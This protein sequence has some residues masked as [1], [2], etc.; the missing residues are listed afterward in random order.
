M[1]YLDIV[2]NLLIDTVRFW[3]DVEY[4][5]PHQNS[6]QT[7]LNITLDILFLFLI[8][9]FPHIHTTGKSIRFSSVV[10]FLILLLRATDNY[11]NIYLNVVVY[12]EVSTLFF[13][14]F[15]QLFI[16]LEIRYKMLLISQSSPISGIYRLIILECYFVK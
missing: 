1:N 2:W 15:L 3:L 5:R 16:D 13:A 12:C 8:F 6:R 7:A 9:I 14:L 4:L 11:H 10:F